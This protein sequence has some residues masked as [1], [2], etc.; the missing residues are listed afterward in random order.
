MCH[1]RCVAHNG[2]NCGNRIAFVYNGLR[3]EKVYE[4]TTGVVREGV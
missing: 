4:M 3:P 1:F 2:R